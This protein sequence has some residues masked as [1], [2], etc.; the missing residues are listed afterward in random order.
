MGPSQSNVF[1]NALLSKLS[2]PAMRLLKL[3][4]Y[5]VGTVA[6]LIALT[7]L[8]FAIILQL[9]G[10][11]LLFVIPMVVTFNLIQWLIAPYLIE[12]IYGVHEA[13]PHRYPRLHRIVERLSLRSGIPKPKVMIAH[14]PI[15]NAFAYG[16]PISGSRVAVTEKLLDVL[17]EEEVEAVLGHELGHL[18]HRDVHIMMFASVLPAIFYYLAYSLMMSAYYGGYRD[19][20][21][22]NAGLALLIGMASL[23]LYYVV[24]LVVLYLSRLREYYAD[25]HSVSV[26]DDGARKLSEAL[27]KIVAYTGR[28]ASRRRMDPGVGAFKALFIADPDTS[29]NDAVR[30]ARY[31]MNK[32]MQLVMSIASRRLTW[33][34]RLLEIFSTHPNIVKRIR[35]LLELQRLPTP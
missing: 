3:K 12:M 27:A 20:E 31:G 7:T 24:S 4:L 16:S 26:V 13:P 11:P 28:Y 15:P 5:M 2:R 10:A 30:L 1:K 22:G 35:A 8:F 25:M 18:K 32:D 23:V 19:R 29:R 9:A 33:A 17:E 21:G 6:F 14:I 34:D